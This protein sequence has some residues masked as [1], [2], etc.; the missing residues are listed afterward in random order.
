MIRYISL[1]PMRTE[2]PL[3]P[4]PEVY[5]W[6][7]YPVLLGVGS[8][9]AWLTVDWVLDQFGEEYTVARAR[10]QAFVEEGLLERPLPVGGLYF[11][12]DSF[13]REKTAELEPIP[14]VPR[15]HWQPLR[16]H[17]SE[18]FASSEDPV[19]AAYRT[20]G[21]TLGEIAGYVGCHCS[22]VSRRLRRS[23]LRECKT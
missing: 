18:I 5:P 15:A 16:P 20:Y 22:T 6:S 1:N 19:A 13:I 10:L 3:C 4:A 9:P 21:Y 12:E 8:R 14:K 7:S 23:E 2:P 17:L 11:A